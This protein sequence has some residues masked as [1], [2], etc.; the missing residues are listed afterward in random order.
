MPAPIRPTV[1]SLDGSFGVGA[2][3]IGRFY[4]KIGRRTF[5]VH[6]HCVQAA[7]QT[8]AQSPTG[9]SVMRRDADR[10]GGHP[11]WRIAAAAAGELENGLSTG[12]R[13]PDSNRGP[14]HYE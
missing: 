4:K 7:E 13:R 10:R 8:A 1:I 2:I 6:E 9:R 11:S 3:P 5:G 14:H 12:S